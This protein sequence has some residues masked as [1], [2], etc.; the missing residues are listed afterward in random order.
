M[1]LL[2]VTIIM[3]ETLWAN[4][5]D[6]CVS[7]QYL[8]MTYDGL[9]YLPEMLF[10]TNVSQLET[11][12]LM[13][14]RLNSNTSWSDVLMPL[15]ELKYLNLSVNMLTSWTYKLNSLLKLEI[16]D[17]SHNT[18][19]SVSSK[20]FIK[21]TILKLLSLEDNSLTFL[22]YDFQILFAQ[23][24]MVH[25]GSNN[26]SRLNISASTIT[27]NTSILELSANSLIQL[28]LPLKKECLSTCGKISLFVD[29]NTLP[30]F[31]LPCSSTQQ[32]STVSLANNQLTDFSSIFPDVFIKQCSI[33]M[34]N[35]SHNSF[36]FWDTFSHSTS[37]EL[38]RHGFQNRQIPTHN[39]TTLDMSHCYIQYISLWAFDG[40]TI[41]F[42]DLRDNS[43]HSINSIPL[44]MKKPHIQIV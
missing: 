30:R 6:H 39:I 23:I 28:D 19:S 15:H 43:I 20:P 1:I 44:P 8:S 16:L 36:K 31:I 38:L 26:I 37:Y 32:Y 21:M 14:N 42:L 11:L 5:F 17:L 10:A 35:V 24:A 12:L 13:G 9:A 40:F 18:I 2:D 27:S 25:L 7:L 29:N 33:E 34:L 3:T 41:D 22:P 4:I